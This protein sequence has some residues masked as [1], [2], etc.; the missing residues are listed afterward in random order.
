MQTP[1]SMII[2]AASVG[3]TGAQTFSRTAASPPLE[4]RQPNAADLTM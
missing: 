3:G 1:L 2:L 4:T